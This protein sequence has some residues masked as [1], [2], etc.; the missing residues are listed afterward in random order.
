MEFALDQKQSVELLEQNA[1]Y[2]HFLLYPQCFQKPSLPWSV[3]HG[4]IWKRVKFYHILYFAYTMQKESIG[5]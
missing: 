4:M 3:R 5:L 2:Q 1:G